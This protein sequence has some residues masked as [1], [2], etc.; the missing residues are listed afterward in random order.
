MKKNTKI[1]FSKS[2]SI[3]A[4]AALSMTLISGQA[5]TTYA[6]SSSGIESGAVIP[7]N[8][9]IDS[10]TA[11]SN[12][13][14]PSNSYGTLSWVDGYYVPEKRVQSCAVVFKP[15]TG[16]DLSGLPGWDSSSGTLTGYVTV[17]ISSL[18]SSSDENESADSSSDKAYDESDS[19][20]DE[21]DSENKDDTSESSAETSDEK[22]EDSS[23]EETAEN[24][25]VSEGDS[26][27]S[28]SETENG[29]DDNKDSTDVTE[30]PDAQDSSSD[31]TNTDKNEETADNDNAD[32][33]KDNTEDNTTDD[34]ADK[35][36]T[37][38]D[39]ADN[40]DPDITETPEATVTPS[41]NENKADQDKDTDVTKTPEVTVT[42]AEDDSKTDSSSDT[43]K[44]DAEKDNKKDSKDETPDVTETPEEDKDNIFDRKDEEEDK[45]PQNAGTDLTETEKEQ[46]AARNHTCDGITVSGIDLPWYVQFRVSGGEDY[47]FTNEE[48]ATIFKSYEFELW[49]TQKNTEYKIPDGEY[50]SVTVPVK[51]GYTY[52]IEHLLDNGAME[53]IIPS[54]DGGTM[55]FSTHSF[56]PF[57]I[58]GSKSLVGPDAG[59][60]SSSNTTKTTPAATSSTDTTSSSDTPDI[61]GSD[62]TENT[63]SAA[64]LDTSADLSSGTAD[65][66][67]TS[68]QNSTSSDESEDEAS[69]ATSKKQV[70]TGDNTQI[71]PFVILFVA[72]AV[73]AGVAVFFKKRKK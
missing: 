35:D 29:K 62:G 53:T 43:D 72:A 11:L 9:T 42:P 14:L 23:S 66:E 56:S 48:D 4:A 8:I 17:V 7:D 73:V 55:T 50:I 63:D 47:E 18:D 45:R 41:E 44:E 39:T 49:D 65:L 37:D 60:D 52:S 15:S 54:V 33:K 10:P 71:L 13:A 59:T 40:A 1:T 19:Y 5:L 36:S 22:S 21:N 31:K 46:T 24:G 67:G 25:N 16:A 32:E 3:L 2:F 69:Q 61:T 34:S 38:K 70:N 6:G 68:S 51:A 20:K 58:A 27:E 30:T 12:V 64:D 57:G 26:Y 28:S